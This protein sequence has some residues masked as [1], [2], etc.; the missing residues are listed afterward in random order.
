[1]TLRQIMIIFVLLWATFVTPSPA[2][3]PAPWHMGDARESGVS[4][5]GPSSDELDL[6]QANPVIAEEE[7][8]QRRHGK[9]KGKGPASEV[10]D[11][12]THDTEYEVIEK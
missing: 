8:F 9:K 10:S 7:E 6:E 2:A 5:R 1:M 11:K 12:D 4:Q 3:P